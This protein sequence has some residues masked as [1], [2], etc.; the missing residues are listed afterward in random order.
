MEG[1]GPVLAQG[2]QMVGGGVAFVASQAVR[3]IDGVP[4]EHARV[5]MRLGQDGSG[6][7]GDAAGVSVDQRF[8]L[9]EDIELDGVE[10]EIIGQNRELVERG[11]HGLAAGL[12]NIPGVDAL[13]VDFGDGPGERVFAN[14]WSQLSATLGD[15]FFGVVEADDAA[16]GIQNDG[17]GDHRAEQRAAARFIEAGDARP[18]Q[19]AGGAFET[20]ATET[21]HRDGAILARA[22]PVFCRKA[23]Q[24]G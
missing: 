14:A 21:S 11:G 13:G 17:S 6:G 20:G 19:F 3:R 8:L 2:F 4:F 16:L 18:A 22:M 9:D 5:A 23:G 7:D 24:A 1:R 10:Q 12:I 15:K